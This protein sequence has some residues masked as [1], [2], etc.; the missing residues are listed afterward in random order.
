MNIPIYR[1]CNT[2]LTLL[3]IYFR[4]HD[5][6]PSYGRVHGFR[7]NRCFYVLCYVGHPTYFYP[8]K[9]LLTWRPR[10]G[11][12]IISQ[13]VYSFGGSGFAGANGSMMIEVVVSDAV[14]MDLA[15]F[16]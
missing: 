8:F 2:V 9:D 5:Y 6:V 15:S 11:R 12:T 13:L 1:S 3:L 4:W 14:T 16:T 7:R 10:P